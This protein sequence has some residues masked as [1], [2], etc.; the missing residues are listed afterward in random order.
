MLGLLWAVQAMAAFGAALL[1]LRGTAPSPTPALNGVP[2]PL[3]AAAGL[4]AGPLPI[5][6]WPHRTIAQRILRA[7]GAL[8]AL[9]LL[10]G[11]RSI[12]SLTDLTALAI[13]ILS[14]VA[15]AQALAAWTAED[16]Y[17]RSRSALQAVAWLAL[18]MWLFPTIALDAEGRAWPPLTAF[19]TLSGVLWLLPLA[20][21]LG[22]I[23]AALAQFAIEGRGTGFPYDPPKRL[24]S[25]GIYAYVA[26]PM[27]LGIVAL[28]GWWGLVIG[29]TV[30]VASA[31]VA[32]MLFLVF[33]N[34]CNGTSNVSIADP[35]WTAYR[36]NVPV[37]RVRRRPWRGES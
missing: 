26:N 4:M 22:L 24:V 19:A 5:L 29:S 33:R 9:L 12:W 10:H 17:P 11:S 7:I 32:L 28:M 37:W 16:R 31:P 2:L 14:I 25:R 3:L 30:V 21:P 1:E 6:L 15:P 8:I 13:A 18:L 27:Q 34:V 23:L 36:R 35:H 20:L